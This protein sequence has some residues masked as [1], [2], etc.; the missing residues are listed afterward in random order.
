MHPCRLPWMPASDHRLIACL[1]IGRSLRGTLAG[2]RQGGGGCGPPGSES[3]KSG[4][5][6]VVCTVSK[7][8]L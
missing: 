7:A 4:V 8:P 1:R 5:S 3:R 2:L 6:R